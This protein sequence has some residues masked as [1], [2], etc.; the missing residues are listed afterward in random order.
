MELFTPLFAFKGAA[1]PEISCVKGAEFAYLFLACGWALAVGAAAQTV[2][3]RLAPKHA[4]DGAV[5][6]QAAGAAMQAG[7]ALVGTALLLGKI[8]AAA[9]SLSGM[10]AQLFLL[11]ALKDEKST[12]GETPARDKTTSRLME[13]AIFLAVMGAA[14]FACYDPLIH[15][16]DIDVHEGL[17]LAWVSHLFSGIRPGSGMALNYGPLYAFSLAGFLAS[18]G[19]T[20]IQE[21]W[22][23]YVCQVAGLLCAWVVL[24]TLCRRLVF[25]FAGMMLFAVLTVSFVVWYGYANG[26][27]PGLGLLAIL[28]GWRAF[29]DETDDGRAWR[30]FGAGALLGVSFLYSPETGICALLATAVP[31]LFMAVRRGM[32]GAVGRLAAF[33]AGLAS[34]VVTVVWVGFSGSMTEKTGAL[35]EY[36]RLYSAGFYSLPFPPLEVPSSGNAGDIVLFLLQDGWLGYAQPVIYI[37]V[38]LETSA[39]AITGTFRE[40]RRWLELALLV[41]G[42]ASF[43]TAMGRSDLIHIRMASPAAV[44]L[45]ACQIERG[46][47]VT[48]VWGRSR[49]W[50]RSGLAFSWLFIVIF[51]ARQA[52]TAY[53]APFFWAVGTAWSAK[54]GREAALARRDIDTGARIRWNHP[55]AGVLWTN[56][57]QKD[58]WTTAAGLLG[59]RLAPGEPIYA[60]FGAELAYFL[61]GH[62]SPNRFPVSL[63]AAPEREQKTVAGSLAKVRFL[64][65]SRDINLDGRPWD[66]YLPTVAREIKSSFVIAA[67]GARMDVWKRKRDR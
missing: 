33:A 45:L 55:R 56:R 9:L 21:R 32:G 46:W 49:G 26:L 67:K 2:A 15:Y 8:S 31:A 42:A 38:A 35:F 52:V 29:A 43:R 27:R 53:R 17:H 40:K 58:D 47:D 24:R 20:V 50:F 37:V 63:E 6:C 54:S 13:S 65:I 28:A 14:A 59:E 25:A 23:F 51:V 1:S 39:A 5:L 3:R 57:P 11:S 12:G 41:F 66:E 4:G 30:C 61:T 22:Y 16:R 36:L 62:N 48:A 44:I 19:V 34:T 7:L 64:V 18:T 10:V 60:N